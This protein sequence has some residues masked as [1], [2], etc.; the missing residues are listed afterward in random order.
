VKRLRD[1][2][3]VARKGLMTFKVTADEDNEFTYNADVE[4]LKIHEERVKVG[5]GIKGRCFSFTLANVAGSDFDIDSV[6]I[7]TEIIRRAR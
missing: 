2:W 7:L 4:N 5:R 3:I 6:R 1:A